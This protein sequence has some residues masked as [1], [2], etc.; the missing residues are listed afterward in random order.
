VSRWEYAYITDWGNERDVH[1]PDGQTRT[2]PG[3]ESIYQVVCSLGD[4]GWELAGVI[5]GTGDETIGANQELWFKRP[6][7]G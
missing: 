3:E 1:L 2:Y 6:K 5:P 4:D 7:E